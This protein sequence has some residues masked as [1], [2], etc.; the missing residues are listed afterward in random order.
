MAWSYNPSNHRILI[1]NQ[2]AVSNYANSSLANT[3]NP[4]YIFTDGLIYF[5][6]NLSSDLHILN[7]DNDQGAG[8]IGL[9]YVQVI[10]ITGG[11][12]FNRTTPPPTVPSTTK[13]NVPIGA[14][15]G[16][17]VGIGIPLLIFLTLLAIILR[18]RRRRSDPLHGNND[19]ITPF[20][21]ATPSL[22]HSEK[23]RTTN[24]I[25]G[26]PVP[27]PLSSFPTTT[28]TTTS[29]NP[30]LYPAPDR[31]RYLNEKRSH[32]ANVP[33]TSGTETPDQIRVREL[34]TELAL[35]RASGEVNTTELQAMRRDLQQLMQMVG[36]P[37]MEDDLIPPPEYAAPPRTG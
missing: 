20:D 28:T 35:A 26:F 11:T 19:P 10:S 36:R 23:T 27:P 12:P 3:G 7:V 22:I 9:D 8:W 4:G 2:P 34:Q 30:D 37:G 14:I 16:P 18:R 15:V 29:S 32:V 17:I 13:H 25:S 6:A 31:G 24:P 5:H 21:P 33:S 1:D